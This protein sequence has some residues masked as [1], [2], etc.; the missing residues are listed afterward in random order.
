MGSK[1]FNER[2]ANI[3]LFGYWVSNPVKNQMKDRTLT[4]V[5]HVPCLGTPI[6]A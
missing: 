1:A 5:H 6:P 3:L 4:V 2:D